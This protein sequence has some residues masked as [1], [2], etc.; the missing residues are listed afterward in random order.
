MLTE[1][2]SRVVVSVINYPELISL[3]G[4]RIQGDSVI[5]FLPDQL[6]V[7]EEEEEPEEML[8]QFGIPE[9]LFTRTGRGTVTTEP[10]SAFRPFS[11]FLFSSSLLS[12][13]V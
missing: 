13:S 4:G 3:R 11:S 12:V 8:K 10:V 1:F 5:K 6:I 9:A 7:Q 2:S